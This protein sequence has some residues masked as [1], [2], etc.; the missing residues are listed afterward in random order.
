MRD[1]RGT[2][3]YH[4]SSSLLAARVVC[5]GACTGLP[6]AASAAAITASATARHRRCCPLD[7]SGRPP[8]IPSSFGAPWGPAARG[9]SCSKR[10]RHIDD[11]RMLRCSENCRL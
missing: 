9:S 11:L 4:R 7:C 8:G 3:R 2:D 6:P 1:R 10:Q 5:F